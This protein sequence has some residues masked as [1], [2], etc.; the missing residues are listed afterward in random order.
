MLGL[1]GGGGVSP[2]TMV[3]IMWMKIKLFWKISYTLQDF[4][5]I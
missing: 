3:E 2:I 5:V 4:G 1:G